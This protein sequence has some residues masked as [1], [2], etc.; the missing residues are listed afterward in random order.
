[1]LVVDIL[2]VWEHQIWATLSVGLVGAAKAV[3]PSSS[4]FALENQRWKI[5]EACHL[6][7]PC[8][9]PKAVRPKAYSYALNHVRSDKLVIVTNL[10]NVVFP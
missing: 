7:V 6:Q 3:T 4:I 5:L 10:Y 2:W 1:M 9:S 8:D